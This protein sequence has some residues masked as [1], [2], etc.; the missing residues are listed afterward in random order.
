[1]TDLEKKYLVKQRSENDVKKH[2][3]IKKAINLQYFS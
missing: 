3:S 2:G 1:M